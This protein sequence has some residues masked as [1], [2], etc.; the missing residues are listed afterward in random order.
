[1][2]PAVPDSHPNEQQTLNMAPGSSSS[3]TVQQPGARPAQSDRITASENSPP[4]VTQQ[5]PVSRLMDNFPSTSR[6]YSQMSAL[7]RMRQIGPALQQE[8][9]KERRAA[10]ARQ[11]QPTLHGQT[12]QQQQ[13]LPSSSHEQAPLPLQRHLSYAQQPQRQI[14]VPSSHQI[15]QIDQRMPTMSTAQGQV[16]K[17]KT[18]ASRIKS[19]VNRIS[20]PKV[21]PVIPR[22]VKSTYKRTM[23]A[24]T[25]CDQDELITAYDEPKTFQQAVN[26]DDAD[27]WFEAINNELNA[28]QK[29][30]T[31]TIVPKPAGVNEISSKWIF[32]VKYGTDGKID[33]FKA[34]L[35]ARG[36]SQVAGVDF[37]EIFAPV[38]RM[39]SVRLLF[40]ICAQLN[41]EFAQFDVATAFLNG[42][43]DEELYLSPPE[44]LDIAKGHTCRLHKSLYGL[45]QAPRC[46]N[47]KFVNMLK[48]FNMKQL[49]SDP[50]V[51]V[52]TDSDDVVY[53][54]LYVDD[55]L[56]FAKD[57]KTIDRVI[58]YLTKHFEIKTVNS[59]CFV[60]LEIV[61]DKETSSIFLHQ[62]SYIKR[63]LERFRMMDCK[64]AAT[65]LEVG[66]TLN[67]PETLQDEPTND[68]PY[69]EAIGS[70]LY[71]AMGTRPDLAYA[72]SVLSKFTKNP[73]PLHWKAVKRV[74]RYLRGTIDHGL[75]YQPIDRPKIMCF[76]DADYAGDQL[77]G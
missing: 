21:R 32:K 57:R 54:A 55:G 1:M 59:A 5:S 60:G 77:V 30:G 47:T 71:C 18:V 9:E 8:L 43:L 41:L 34:R 48:I 40:S 53:L 31:W 62:R 73:R 19:V 61:Q 37:G 15:S 12:A 23:L 49:Q 72:L 14:A 17:Q 65:P 3:Q 28:H 64:A 22:N 68:V 13:L 20:P 50:C 52:N 69:A 46:W 38:V 63:V 11:A 58:G 26:S 44:G 39:D 76:T 7:E 36:F 29:N 66:H 45:R 56:I 10:K 2:E 67:K 42:E 75:I 6:D 16:S 70:L 51:F 4:V 35:V 25:D 24:V 27:K 33:R 74:F